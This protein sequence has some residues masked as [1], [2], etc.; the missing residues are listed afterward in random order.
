MRLNPPLTT[1]V[2]ALLA[3]AAWAL[4]FA[5]GPTTLTLADAAVATVLA[6]ALVYLRFTSR[7]HRPPIAVRAKP[8]SEAAEFRRSLFDLC[9]ALKLGIGFCERHLD[10]EPERLIEQ[11]EQMD[12]NIRT[13]VNQ[14]VHPVRFDARGGLRRLPPRPRWPWHLPLRMRPRP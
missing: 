4:A 2:C 3:G 1:L 11:L 12:D 5:Q 13:F 8:Q 10:S 9:A 7:P 6:A 14:V